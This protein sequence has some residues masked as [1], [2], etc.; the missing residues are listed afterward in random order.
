MKYNLE[1]LKADIGEELRKIERLERAFARVEPS[2]GLAAEEVDGYDRGAIG[3]YL[4]NFYNGCENI[5]RGKR[6]D[7]PRHPGMDCRDPDAMEGKSRGWSER[8]RLGLVAQEG[9]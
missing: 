7:P 2:L 1:L 3:Y 6:S 4:H 8:L 5:F 9:R